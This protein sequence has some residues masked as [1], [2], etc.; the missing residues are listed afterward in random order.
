MR[1]G[2]KD[3]GRRG[4]KGVW[5]PRRGGLALAGS[6][7]VGRRRQE[8]EGAGWILEAGTGDDGRGDTGQGHMRGGV[9]A[10][11]E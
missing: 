6:C 10:T 9:Q 8:L 4:G 7:N 1:E 3:D 2:G 11:Q 5:W